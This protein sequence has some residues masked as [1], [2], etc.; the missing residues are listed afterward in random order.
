[1]QDRWGPIVRPEDLHTTPVPV[2]RVYDGFEEKDHDG[3][4]TL[5]LKN[6]YSL[7]VGGRH[8]LRNPLELSIELSSSFKVPSP[9]ERACIA[10]EVSGIPL[11]DSFPLGDVL[12]SDLPI[13][14]KDKNKNKGINKFLLETYEQKVRFA[15][16]MLHVQRFAP[17]KE[18]LL[19]DS[20]NVE[21]WR[22]E[23]SSGHFY[24]NTGANPV[25][26]E[27]WVF[28]EFVETP[29]DRYSSFRIVP[30][31][32]GEVHYGLVT[33]SSQ[34][35][36]DDKKIKIDPR[37]PLPG[38]DMLDP[39]HSTAL[40]MDP[41]SPFY[42]DSKSVVSNI[43]SGGKGILL[44]GKPLSDTEDR[45]LVGSLGIN[46]DQPEIPAEL[47]EA[48]RKIGTALRAGIPFMGIDF[49][50]RESGEFV[51]L[52][53]NTGPLLFY[54]TFGKPEGISQAELYYKMY[55][56]IIERAKGN[57]PQAFGLAA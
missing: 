12:N 13:V 1:M 16:W 38:L 35:K 31:A 41:N 11:P 40:L 18:R 47:V 49:M 27:G 43:L 30:D 9:V 17:S 32:Y 36:S 24:I 42:L 21:R 44:N 28:E 46:P 48:S 26:N 19:T 14:A 56:R 15:A 29:G 52:E 5:F 54:G 3:I 45:D 4:Q 23:V 22:R 33:S 51:L 34:K 39:F 55:E 10:S 2:V 6:G 8:N 53:V 37:P 50:R 25:W 20:E 57:N 7:V